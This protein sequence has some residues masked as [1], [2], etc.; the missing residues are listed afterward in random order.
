MTVR[1]GCACD[2]R[3]ASQT[4]RCRKSTLP[5]TASQ[6]SSP[7][8]AE[9]L[10]L[11]RDAQADEHRRGYRGAHRL[12]HGQQK[13][14]SAAAAAAAAAASRRRRRAAAGAAAAPRVAALVE[15]TAEELVDEIPVRAVQLDPVE[16]RVC[17]PTRRVG[18]VLDDAQDVGV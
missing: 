4:L 7:R 10:A 18:V 9:A 17:D 6:S 11:R 8:R 12:Q 2:G 3:K 14:Q 13:A 1:A 15:V 16:S 5:L